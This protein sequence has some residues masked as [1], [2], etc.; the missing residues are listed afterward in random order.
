MGMDWTGNSNGPERICQPI[1][2]LKFG[3]EYARL[4]NKTTNKKLK[5]H[6]GFGA[7]ATR[8]H[9]FGREVNN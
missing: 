9:N 5:Q 1:G 4:T 2:F 3:Q 6:V 8:P 7:A